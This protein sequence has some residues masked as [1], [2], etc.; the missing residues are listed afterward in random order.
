L[1]H[2]EIR[3]A[4]GIKISVDGLDKAVAGTQVMVARD[5]TDHDELEYIKEEVMKDF[6]TILQSV[7]KSGMGVYVQALTLGSLEALLEFL[8]TS[9]IPVSGI[10]IC[11]VH[12]KDVTK[13]STML[14]KRKEFA[15]IL[16][17][18]VPVEKEA[19]EMRGSWGHDLHR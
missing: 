9:K 4:Q 19:R 16:D 3:A 10:N 2:K 8:P 12:K 5:P 13:A 15:I 17:F 1:Q 11:P 6:A 14:E 18:D 7:D